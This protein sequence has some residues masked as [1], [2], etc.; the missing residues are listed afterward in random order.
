[1]PDV[2]FIIGQ[3]G[4]F[5]GKPW[6]EARHEVNRAQ[7]EVAAETKRSAFVSSDGLTAKEDNTHFNTQSLHEF[8]QRYAEAW[9]EIAGD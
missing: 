1:M 8:G 3:L 4:Q 9:L 6:T 2:P 5:E 7:I